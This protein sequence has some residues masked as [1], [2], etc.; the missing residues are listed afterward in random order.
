MLV[1]IDDAKPGMILSED[2]VLPNGMVLV[3]ASREITEKLIELL[4]RRGIQVVQ[5]YDPAQGSQ[6]ST[7]PIIEEPTEQS[8]GQHPE[9][10]EESEPEPEPE[11]LAVSPPIEVSLS[12]DLMKAAIRVEP[13][14]KEGETLTADDVLAALENKGVFYGIDER[15]VGDALKQWEKARKP[16]VIDPIAV[17]T[18]PTPGREGAFEF[19]VQAVT[20]A[21][22]LSE[23][24]EATAY[25]T[26]ADKPFASCD[27]V[28]QGSVIAQRDMSTPPMP[29][30]NVLGELVPTSEI[31]RIP[32]KLDTSADFSRDEQKVLARTAGIAFFVNGTVG[33]V[34]VNFDGTVELAVSSDRMTA[35]VLI[36]PPGP[37]GALPSS[38]EIDR[39]LRENVIDHGI[40]ERLL[41]ALCKALDSGKCPDGAITLAQGTPAQNGD[42]GAVEYLFNTEF[43]LKP[44]ANPDGSVDFK[45]LS[46]VQSVVKGAEL[47]RLIPPTKGKPGKDVMGREIPCSDGVAALLPAGIN[48]EIPEL[49]KD[50]LVASTDGNVRLNNHSVEISEGFVVKGDVDLNTGNINYAKSVVVSGDVKAGFVLECGGD[51]E[52][53][54]TIED[55]RVVV[56]GNVLCKHGVLGQGKG[57]ID[58]KGEVNI[59]FMKNQTIRCRKSVVIAK[60]AINATIYARNSITV[61]G[62]PLSVAGGTLVARDSITV[63]AVGNSSHIKSVLEVGV[64][65]A[66][67]EELKNTETHLAEVGENLK[68]LSESAR[69]FQQ[70]LAIRRKLQPKE[71]FLYAKL[72]NTLDRYH[73]QM[74]DLE[75]RKKTILSKMQNTE[76]AFIKI[77]RAAMPGTV[78]KIGDRY[79]SVKEELVG[80]KTIRSIKA[81]IRVL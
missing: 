58:C 72:K 4:R 5:A 65:F 52:V 18:L 59:G 9:E 2:V 43:S 8:P 68:K 26:I 54:G 70:L 74:R 19:S 46:I 56:G 29:G 71:E 42:N 13:T 35:D 34:P 1:S 63:Y 28:E 80:P 45:S 77:E 50:V 37:G 24:R 81:Q 75:E 55:A 64:D 11:T 49:K 39:L 41:K 67:V 73:Q 14:G 79:F 48:T 32:M 3:N 62:K 33:V 23:L 40:D 36:H 20:D 53:S 61:H 17:G 78:F 38:K 69:K 6:A 51:L 16:F 7:S 44:K 57:T 66:L 27:R 31:Q 47:A 30:K 25:W 76:N 10:T 15:A 21:A 12:D 60:E 22:Q